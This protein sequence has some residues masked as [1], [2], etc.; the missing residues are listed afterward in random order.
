[1]QSLVGR[2]SS[3][4]VGRVGEPKRESRLTASTA[5]EGEADT[6]KAGRGDGSVRT[7][8]DDGR[9]LQPQ[10]VSDGKACNLSKRASERQEGDSRREVDGDLMAQSTLK[11]K[12]LR[13]VDS[14]WLARENAAPCIDPS[15]SHPTV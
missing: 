14:P 11:C 13:G 10:Q 15:N 1:M 12:K 8:G 4:V 5:T 2:A 3:K 7:G 9:D 6:G